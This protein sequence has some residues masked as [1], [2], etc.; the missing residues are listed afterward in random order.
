MGRKRKNQNIDLQNQRYG[1][2]ISENS[3]EIDQAYGRHYLEQ[4]VNFIIKLYRVNVI[5][6]KAH[7]LYGQAKAKDKRFF[8]PI[9]L[10]AMVNIEDNEQNYL[11]TDQG[12]TREDSGNLVVSVFLREL[13]EK[14]TEINR[15]DIIE[16]NLS[17]QRPRYYE[18]ENAQNVVDS[19]SQTFAGMRPFWKRITAVPVKEDVTP[20]LADDKLV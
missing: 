11:G 6:T 7:K 13:E 15:G 3:Y 18:V 2:F 16:Y 4:D 9:E 17:G 12:L 8:S 1:I 20:Y 5:E 10:Y 19:T 14:N